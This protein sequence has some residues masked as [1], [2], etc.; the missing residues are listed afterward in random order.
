MCVCVCVK[1]RKRES[2]SVNVS[3]CSDLRSESEDVFRF[4]HLNK[5]RVY[6]DRPDP[7]HTHARLELNLTNFRI[8][9]SN[10]Q[11]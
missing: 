7:T 11:S 6:S 8:I 10:P 1:E 3:V 4:E 9:S 2:G 5:P